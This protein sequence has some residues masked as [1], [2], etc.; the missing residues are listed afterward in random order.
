MV[1]V[2]SFEAKTHLPALLDRVVRGETV[3][4]TKRGVPVAKLVPADSPGKRDAKE[5]AEEIRRM[6]KGVRLGK[7]SIRNLIDE[8][9][10]H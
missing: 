1:T 4:I 8:G 5:T 6:R 10:R 7:I 9:R 2:G 3:Q